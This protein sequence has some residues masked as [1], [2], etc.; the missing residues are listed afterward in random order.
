MRRLSVLLM[1]VTIGTVAGSMGSL[2]AAEKTRP[3]FVH[4][5]VFHLKKDVSPDAS[6]RIIADAR[7]LLGHVPSVRELKVG[8]RAAKG[9][10]ELGRTDFE[11]G[12]LVLFDNADGLRAYLDHPKHKEYVARHLKEMESVLVYDFEESK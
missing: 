10:P 2:R 12:L 11:I 4:A 7:E 5:V 6:D 9:T 3:T 8:R 1:G